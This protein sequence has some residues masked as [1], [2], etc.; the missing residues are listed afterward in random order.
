MM[1]SGMGEARRFSCLV[2]GWLRLWEGEGEEGGGW[3]EGEEGGGW[4]ASGE[5][6]VC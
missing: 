2:N 3:E 4:E 5:E 1:S 6:A